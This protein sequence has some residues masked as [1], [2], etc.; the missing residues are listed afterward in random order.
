M[1]GID[2]K[3]GLAV[4]EGGAVSG[5]YGAQN[6]CTVFGRKV[7]RNDRRKEQSRHS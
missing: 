3:K 2:R 5:K 7:G 1:R 4:M 6:G